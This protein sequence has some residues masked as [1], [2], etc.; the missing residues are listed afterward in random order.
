M[1]V[2]AP[3][4]A[5]LAE[6]NNAV[7]VAPP[8]AGKTTAV[9][10]A[11]LDE[12]WAKDK[13]ILLLSP[14][15]LAARAAAERMAYLSGA[16]LGG[17]IGFR[18]RL[19]QRISKDTR[20]EVITEGIFVRRI[21]ADP[22][23]Q[24]VAAVLFDE[25]HE[26]SLDSDTGLA[27]AL[28]AQAV[29]RP[30]LRLIAMS[31]TLDGAR[32]AALMG[33][34]PVLESQG[35]MYP[36]EMR[37]RPRKADERIA[38]AVV[39]AIHAALAQE[40]GSILVFLPGAGDIER[41]AEQVRVPADVDLHRLYGARDGQSQR[42]A[43]APPPQGRR[44]L[45]LATS[46]AETSITID[47]V[48][49][50]IDS[51]LARRARY[52]RSTGL[53]R[54]V[55]ERASLAAVRQRAGRA[56]R[57]APGVCIRLWEEAGTAGLTPFDPPEI[58]EADLSG[59]LLDLAVW[60]V[61]DPAQLAW[62]DP[63]PLAAVAEARDRLMW[64]EALDADG[65]ITD[66]G[67][68]MAKLPLSPRLAH[69]LLR[70]QEQQMG[71]TAAHMAV[72]LSEQTLGGRSADLEERLRLWLGARDPRAQAAKQMAVRWAKSVG[73][74]GDVDAQ[75]VGAVLALAFPDRVAKR[76][77]KAQSSYIMANGR[78]VTVD[79]ATVLAQS[80]WI[81]VADAMGAAE[82]ARLMAGAVLS[83]RQVQDSVARHGTQKNHVDY[84]AATGRVIAEE[85][86]YLGA[87]LLTKRPIPNPDAGL[88]RQALLQAFVGQDFATWGWGEAAQSL[89]ARV[90]F[91][92]AQGETD[93]P[94]L[95]DVHLRATAEQWLAP[96]LEGVRKV[97]AIDAAL[98]HR[99]LETLV[100]WPT[101]QRIEK[102]A[103]AHF[104]S[105]LGT[106]HAIDYAAEA[107]PTVSIRVQALF[108]MTQHPMVCQGRIPLTLALLS[109][110]GRP[111]QTTKDLPGFWAGSWKAVKAEMKGRYPKHP[112]PD[113]PAEA[114]PTTRTKAADARRGLP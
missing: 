57:T 47:G 9:A 100:D 5:A 86:D 4:K 35:R 96:H 50:V 39:S 32:Y 97:S 34:A 88:V 68:A 19:E 31:A 51:G 92:R 89:R 8:G 13:R 84:D 63:P 54:L 36:V 85:R 64:L 33:D 111:I 98:L 26:R 61:R 52:D 78:A 83:A 66:H 106:D 37:Y 48:R 53:T 27:L 1:E 112:W 103:P 38:E 3:L 91:L 20:I 28:E 113:N 81:V 107:G 16:P 69:M 2:L 67:R 70:A 102:L 23:L 73:A 87:I 76:R 101:R 30:D 99:A 41:V 17:L 58:L 44:K 14:R 42:A 24:G 29:L 7:L 49:V 6:T 105:A 18:T 11:L 15:R 80:P 109:P 114:R 95:S 46:I 62:L 93:L 45:V 108:G 90:A 12:A 79:A 104:T 60:G 40:E 59:L 43:I 22:E 71:M 77:D 56:G 94:D 25:V 10:P 55:T 74:E 75:D 21:A 82:G 65:Q 110:A 72:L